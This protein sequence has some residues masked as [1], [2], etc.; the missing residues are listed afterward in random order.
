M[1]EKRIECG[2]DWLT[3]VAKNNQ[4]YR[5]CRLNNVAKQSDRGMYG[6]DNVYHYPDGRIEAWATDRPDMGSMTIYNGTSLRNI[7]SAV[8]AMELIEKHVQRGH[9]STRIDLFVDVHNHGWRVKDFADM[10]GEGRAVTF[11]KSALFI[12]QKLGDGDTLWLGKGRP[13]QLRIYDKAAEQG[14]KGDW[15][16][17][18][19]QFRKQQAN[20]AMYTLAQSQ[21]KKSAI[22]A[23]IRGT[24]DFP[25][26][27]EW[28]EVFSSGI[29]RFSDKKNVNSDRYNWIMNTVASA[30]VS[31]IIYGD[32][33]ILDKL[34]DEV[35]R[36]VN[37][38][39]TCHKAM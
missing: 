33:D 21:D 16:R 4:S 20:Q 1:V 26:C 14:I 39:I 13:K 38:E 12:E 36:R 15:V 23:A 31:E 34:N 25:K 37:E 9:R 7:S 17:I 6:Y 3:I 8:G 29:M 19:A 27:Q 2:V 35:I 28:C 10:V 24:V 5:D 22:A 32:K 11:I 18:E 30:I